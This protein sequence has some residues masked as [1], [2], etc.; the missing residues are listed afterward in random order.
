MDGSMA[1][2]IT[3]GGLL[4]LA[5]GLIYIYFSFSKKITELQEIVHNQSSILR[6]MV[7]R[8]DYGPIPKPPPPKKE[9]STGEVEKILEDIPDDQIT[10][11]TFRED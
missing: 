9:V 10:E 6:K 1:Q 3:Y 2:Y 4:L 5:V 11:K 7:L 8:D